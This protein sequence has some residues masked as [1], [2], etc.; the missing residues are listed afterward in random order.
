LVTSAHREAFVRD[1][2]FV[3]EG[4]MPREHVELL[5][6]A[7]DYYIDRI[8]E[9]MDRTGLD[10]MGIN[11]RGSRYFISN[12]WRERPEMGDFLFS[13]YMANICQAALGDDVYL[14][15][16]QFVIKAAE[17]GMKFAWHQDSGYVG[18]THR[19]YLSCWCAL[20]DMTVENGTVYML[21]YA[22][23]GVRDTVEHR[24]D[25]VTNDRVGYFGDDPGEPV[26]CPAG[27]I[28]VFSSNCFH[29]S[30]TNTTSKMRRVY[31]AQY[32]AEPIIRPMTD[33]KYPGKMHALA[34]P[35]LKGGTRATTDA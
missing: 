19:E 17:K 9:E 16:E 4:V 3:L 26:I 7:G 1:G 2:F 33:P 14:F 31:L 34:D 28:A 25:A 24:T 23:A 30:G 5:R 13:D 29:R 15:N 12:K 8:H 21:P 32:S 11:H 18:Y 27:S 35:F 6:A 20:D 10:V 22:R